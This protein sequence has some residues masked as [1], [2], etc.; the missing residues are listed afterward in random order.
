MKHD[1]AEPSLWILTK[2]SILKAIHNTC[3]SSTEVTYLWILTKISILK[4]IHN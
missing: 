2:I 4:A 1:A 3:I